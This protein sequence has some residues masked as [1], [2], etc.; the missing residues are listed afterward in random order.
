MLGIILFAAA[1]AATSESSAAPA[2]KDAALDPKAPVNWEAFGLAPAQERLGPTGGEQLFALAGSLSS[3]EDTDLLILQ[4][5]FGYFLDDALEV[6]G[7]ITT[8]WFD[9]DCDDSTLHLINPYVNYNLR[10][11][12]RLWYYAGLH[13]GLAFIDVAGT[14]ETGF[15]IGPHAG[16][17]YWVSPRSAFFAEPR[18]TTAFYSG[19]SSTEVAIIF[20]FTVMI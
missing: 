16:A 14:D 5:T 15:A 10:Q 2:P 1:L 20:G 11:T 17:R 6:G 9:A 8:F 4:A 18:L 12:P 13:A 19:D 7:Q 3:V